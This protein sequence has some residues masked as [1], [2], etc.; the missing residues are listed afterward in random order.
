MIGVTRE[1]VNKQLRAWQEERC[2]R[3]DRGIITITDM[4]VLEEL[5]E[6]GT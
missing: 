3:V 6:Q 1:S 5:A 4:A 2:I